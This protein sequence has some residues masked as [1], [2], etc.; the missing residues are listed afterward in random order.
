MA[1]VIAGALIAGAVYFSTVGPS[2][3]PAPTAAPI[4]AQVTPVGAYLD[5]RPVTS[6]DHIR[7]P[8]NAKITILEYSDLE[9]PYCKVFHE[10]MVQ[11]LK[12]YPNDVRWVYRHAPIEQLHKK[13]HAEANASECAAAQGKFWEFTDVIF[14]AT[15]SNDFINLDDLPEYARQAGVSDIAQFTACVAENRFVAKVEADLQD[16]LKA[17]APAQFGTPF[18]MIVLPD[19]TKTRLGGGVPYSQLKTTI[20]SIL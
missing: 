9:C 13:A 12:D 14:A 4:V 5:I 1:I 2:T 16:G 10:S 20:D 17:A 19:G 7:G 11:V 15:K 6:E 8:E 3:L 18:N